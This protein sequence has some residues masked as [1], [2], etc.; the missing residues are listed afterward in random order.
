ME[1][2]HNHGHPLI[3]SRKNLKKQPDESLRK[4]NRY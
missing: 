3:S 4:K 1:N 2:I